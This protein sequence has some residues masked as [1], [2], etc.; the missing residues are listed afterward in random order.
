MSDTNNNNNLTSPETGAIKKSKSHSGSVFV[1]CGVFQ[2]S[3]GSY[4]NLTEQLEDINGQ[5]R[6]TYTMTGF[7]SQKGDSHAGA[8][9][10]PDD[11][12]LADMKKMQLLSFKIIGDG[13]SYGIDIAT[14]DSRSEGKDNHYKK[15]FATEAGKVTEISIYI[16][17]L[18][19]SPFFG[20]QVPFIQDN[21]LLF[22]IHAYSFGE[23]NLKFW[24]IKFS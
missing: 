17:E 1:H 18:S 20:K 14:S 15:I 23:F 3:L 5:S 4:A 9:L 7:M 21:I 12:T 10:F 6:R 16:N 13:K 22:Q 2:D 8:F 11:A 24:D 19:Q